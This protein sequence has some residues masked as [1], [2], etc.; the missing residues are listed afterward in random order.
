MSRSPDPKAKI[1]LLRA[2]EDVFAERGIAGAK[3]E[4]IARKAGLSKGA[5]YLH[6]E[7][8]EAAL[9]QIVETWLARCGSL[10]AGPGDYPEVTDDPDSLLDFCLE[11]DVQIYEFLWQ[12]RVTMRI[13]RSCQGEYHYLFDA[14][15]ADLQGRNREWLDQWRRD[16]L[17]RADVDP[18]LA[19]TLISGAHEELSVKMIRAERRPPIERWVEFA[20][21]MF[22]RA[23]GTPELVAAL[24]RRE[25]RDDEGTSGVYARRATTTGSS[26]K[27][28]S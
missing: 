1:A 10:F 4:D 25:R 21:E 13:L 17:V 7:S 14:F 5:F 6:F 11:R 19:A 28:Q 3:V 16:G 26:Q 8:K 9:K 18:E 2:A 24:E 15:K 27:R 20:Q 22:V 23:F 12:S